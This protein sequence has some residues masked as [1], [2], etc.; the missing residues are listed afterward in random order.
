MAIL[1]DDHMFTFKQIKIMSLGILSLLG[2]I[3]L[4]IRAET[5]MPCGIHDEECIEKLRKEAQEFEQ[6]LAQRKQTLATLEE[7]KKQSTMSLP[8]T[9]EYLEAMRNKEH[10]DETVSKMIQLARTSRMLRS[11]IREDFEAVLNNLLGTDQKNHLK[12]IESGLRALNLDPSNREAQKTLVNDYNIL[13]EQVGLS[14]I[15]T[16]DD[17]TISGVGQIILNRVK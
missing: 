12:Q 2:C 13:A 5:D 17:F 9:L 14:K 10:E 6:R 11:N 7:R 1:G 8:R 3:T 16:V 4:N 15:N